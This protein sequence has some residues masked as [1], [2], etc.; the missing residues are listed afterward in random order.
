MIEAT[1]RIDL[2]EGFTLQH[3][4]DFDHPTL[5]LTN[6]HKAFG[7]LWYGDNRPTLILSNPEL[8]SRF[9]T[10]LAPMQRRW[11]GPFKRGLMFNSAYWWASTSPEL[12]DGKILL[13]NENS[14]EDPKMNGYI[15]V[16]GQVA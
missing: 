16:T 7:T 4:A 11:E 5:T 3:L 15:Q 1:R 9:R 13:L 12:R 8:Y 10:L 14:P 2:V 6:V